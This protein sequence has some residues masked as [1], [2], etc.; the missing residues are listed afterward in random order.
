MCSLWGDLGGPPSLNKVVFEQGLKG[1]ENRGKWL[2]RKKEEV[3][4]S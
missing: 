1:S 3:T 2:S 4:G